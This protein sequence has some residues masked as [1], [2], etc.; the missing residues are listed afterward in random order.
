[1]EFERVRPISMR[2]I[3]REGLREVDDIDGFEGAF[4][5][6]DTATNTEDFGDEGDFGGDFDFDT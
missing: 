1:M 2:R 4:L 5:H 6:A 3:L